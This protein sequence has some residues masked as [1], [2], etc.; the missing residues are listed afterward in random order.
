MQTIQVRTT[1]NLFIHYPLASVGNRILGYLPGLLILRLYTV[2]IVADLP[3]IK[4]LYTLVKDFQPLISRRW[5][6]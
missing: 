1:E 5:K 6:N 4:F 2:A 3:P